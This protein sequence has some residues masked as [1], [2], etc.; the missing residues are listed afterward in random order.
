MDIVRSWVVAGV[1][2]LGLTFAIN[3]VAS[4]EFS[5]VFYVAPFAA[6]IAASLYHAERGAGGWVRHFLAVLPAPAVIAAYG[7]ISHRG[8][9]QSDDQV[10]SLAAEV[11][12]A[13]ALATVGLG[14]VMFG[15]LLLSARTTQKTAPSQNA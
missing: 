13:G 5:Q 1:V 10:V 4:T 3:R 9:P 6:G 15:R 11:G 14:A 7:V 2:Y 12:T 8:L